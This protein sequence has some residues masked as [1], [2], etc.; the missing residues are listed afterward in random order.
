EELRKSRKLGI[1]A[2][3]AGGLVHDFKNLLQVLK[4][5]IAMLPNC[6]SEPE[7][8]LQL[9]QRLDKATDR[10]C[11]MMRDFLVLAGTTEAKLVPVDFVEQIKNTL[12][13]ILPSLPSTVEV[14]LGFASDLPLVL[15][16]SGLLDRVLVNLVKNAGDAMPQGGTITVTADLVHFGS[17]ASSLEKPEDI[18]YL[19][20]TVSDTGSGMDEATCSRIFEPFFTTKKAGKGTGL[21]LAVVSN[22]MEAHHGFI[23]VQSKVGH[24]TSF[25]LYFPVTHKSEEKPIQGTAEELPANSSDQLHETSC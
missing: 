10:G 11:E 5:N 24:G 23:E 15:A 4:L 7:R 2:T 8:L 6:A 14:H 13:L 19:C 1:V 17:V 22:L 3:Q 25:F 18:P 21:G 20:V 16:D 9:A 12:D